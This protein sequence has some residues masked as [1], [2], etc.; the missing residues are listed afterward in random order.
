MKIRKLN[1]FLADLIHTRHIN[2]YCVPLN[3]GYIAA[4]L[5]QQV[6]DAVETTIFKFPDNLIEALKTSPPDV[7]GLS[8]YDW[9]YSLNKAVIQLVREVNPNILIIMGG[10][11]VRKSE[12]ELR[13][14]LIDDPI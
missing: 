5:K 2:N 9:N 1:V 3:V 13:K 12:E 6:G 10:P 14:F 11:N 4:R 7:L 8:N